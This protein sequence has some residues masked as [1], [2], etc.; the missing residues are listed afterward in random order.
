MIFCIG[1]IAGEIEVE[2]ICNLDYFDQRTDIR[3]RPKVAVSVR[4][5]G[6]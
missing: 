4:R 2:N 1:M 3:R 6:R 5:S